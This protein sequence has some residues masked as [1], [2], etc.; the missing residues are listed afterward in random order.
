LAPACRTL[1]SA[2]RAPAREMAGRSSREDSALIVGKGGGGGK[3]DQGSDDDDPGDGDQQQQQ[4]VDD[5]AVPGRPLKASPE[6]GEG[7]DKLL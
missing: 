1:V 5:D 7:P 2:G 4:G 6:P 3:L